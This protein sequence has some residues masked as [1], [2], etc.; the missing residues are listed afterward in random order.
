MDE[1]QILFSRIDDLIC[2]SGQSVNKFYGFLNE[3]Q[4][5]DVSAYLKNK[6]FSYTLYG[7]YSNAS[8]V[9]VAID[10]VDEY[11]FPIS[12]LRIVS[13]GKKVLSHRDYLGAIMGMG[14]K[15]E[16]IGDIVLL[17]DKSSV[18]FVRNEIAEYLIN[19]LTKVGRDS[20]DISYFSDDT[21]ALC[22]NTEELRIIVT[23]MRADNVVSACINCSR[24]VASQLISSDQVF[25]NYFHVSKPSVT[26]S[27]G[28][29]LSIRGYGKFIIGEQTGSTKKD[30]MVISVLRYI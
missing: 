23:S 3:C 16:C 25:L 18:V 12:A 30:R 15:R 7:G 1:S 2:N 21:D 10:D 27:E 6:G 14:V 24:G 9:F 19:E 13:K 5:A 11:S 8:R 17:S 28:D 22:S 4:S 20:V 29:I 26:V